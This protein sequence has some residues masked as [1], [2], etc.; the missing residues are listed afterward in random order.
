MDLLIKYRRFAF[1]RSVDNVICTVG[2]LKDGRDHIL[3]RYSFI[4]TYTV[5][6]E[7]TSLQNSMFTFTV[8]L[9]ISTDDFISHL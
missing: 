9:K 1:H 6:S 2:M 7:A 5:D 4:L 8:T 3:P